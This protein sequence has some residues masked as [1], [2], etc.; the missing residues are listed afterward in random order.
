MKYQNKHYQPWTCCGAAVLAALIWSVLVLETPA[1]DQGPP[2]KG[3]GHVR[4]PETTDL[5]PGAGVDIRGRGA[6]VSVRLA[7]RGRDTM[8]R[9]RLVAFCRARRGRR[10]GGPRAVARRTFPRPGG[11]SRYA[12]RGA[13]RGLRSAQCERPRF[14]LRGRE[15]I[16][17]SWNG[18]EYRT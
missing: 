13:R 6:S 18:G 9:R 3:A 14:S 11:R 10:V 17:F 8:A 15:R 1:S 2:A 4:N 5:R 16:L 7:W 12:P